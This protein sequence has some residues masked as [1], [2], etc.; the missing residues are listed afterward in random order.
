MISL[1][2]LRFKDWPYFHQLYNHIDIEK[3][4]P[5]KD[6]FTSTESF[7][8]FVR[9]IFNLKSDLLCYRAI[10]LN[11]KLIGMI[12]L[13]HYMLIHQTANISFD[14]NP[15]YHGRGFAKIAVAEF[16]HY[17]F[18]HYKLNRINAIV[19]PDNTKSINLLQKV[20]FTYEATLKQYIHFKGALIDVNL[21]RLC[22]DEY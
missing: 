21:Y 9:I 18:S 15:K 20:G 8:W 1:R 7:F 4:L 12:F 22:Q 3:E 2:K 10:C 6:S 5:F 17:V 11:D 19:K 13:D 14:V 16:C